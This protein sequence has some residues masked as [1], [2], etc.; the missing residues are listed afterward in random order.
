[1]LTKTKQKQ[2]EN[3]VTDYSSKTFIW[4]ESSEELFIY[5]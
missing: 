4:N 3:T 5:L 1:M 2:N